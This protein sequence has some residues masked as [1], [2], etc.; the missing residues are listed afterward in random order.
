MVDRRREYTQ[1]VA[2]AV[3]VY[4]NLMRLYALDKKVTDDWFAISETETK[5]YRNGLLERLAKPRAVTAE[6]ASTFVVST[7]HY[8]DSHWADYTTYPTASPDNKEYPATDP[9]KRQ[10]LLQ[11][12]GE[13]KA[14]IDG[15]GNIYN[16]LRTW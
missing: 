13:L 4:D 15:V 12:H 3:E 6:D 2:H 5:T 11:L 16:A 9:E 7:G 14:V 10:R 1:L 8:L